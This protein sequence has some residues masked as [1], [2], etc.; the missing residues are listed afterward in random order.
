MKAEPNDLYEFEPEYDKYANYE[1]WFICPTCN[2]AFE[3]DE[4][5]DYCEHYQENKNETK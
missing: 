5:D 4:P 3:M 2:H 1:M